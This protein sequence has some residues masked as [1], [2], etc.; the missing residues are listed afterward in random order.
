MDEVWHHDSISIKRYWHLMSYLSSNLN[1]TLNQ[2]FQLQSAH[3][4]LLL[5]LLFSTLS[6]LLNFLS[7]FLSYLISL[8]L[9]YVLRIFLRVSTGLSSA[10]FLFL[11]SSLY[12]FYINDICLACYFLVSSWWHIYF[13]LL[14]TVVISPYLYCVLQPGWRPWAVYAPHAQLVIRGR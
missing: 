1:M 11:H 2:L 5:S 12:Y 3:P 14:S 10:I 9:L 6:P 8:L 4:A 13:P 7:S